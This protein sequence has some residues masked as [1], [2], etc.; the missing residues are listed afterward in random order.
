S[1]L[2]VNSLVVGIVLFV[3]LI[4]RQKYVKRPFFDFKALYK[5]PNVAHSLVLLVFL[6]IYLASSSIFTQYTVGVLEYNNVINAKINLWMIPGIIVSGVLAFV[7]FKNK[8]N[9]KYYIAAG[10][11]SFFLH[12]L[13]LYF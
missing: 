11:V 7:S 5:T 12:T 1:P 6:G 2:A 13:S 8:W 10:F 4:I 3:L 9:V